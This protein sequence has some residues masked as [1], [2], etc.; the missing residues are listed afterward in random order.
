MI[1]VL[2]K[3]VSD[4]VFRQFLEY[5]PVA[6]LR[7]SKDGLLSD[8]GGELSVFGLEQ[9]VLGRAAEDQVLFLENML[10]L[11]EEVLLLPAVELGPDRY[12][13]VHLLSSDSGD[14]AILQDR[15]Q[16]IHWRGEAQ[17]KANE[18]NLLRRKLAKIE[19][20]VTRANVRS[21]PQGL[22]Y[23]NA[24][25]MLPME[26]LENGS[27]RLLGPSPLS[28]QSIYPEAF[29]AEKALWPDVKFP[30]IENFLIE[31]REVWASD[32]ERRKSGPWVETDAQGKE[33]ALEAIAASWNEKKILIIEL[34]GDAYEEQRSF[35]QMGRENVLVRKYLEEEVRR[36][37]SDIH[38]RE[39]EI[40]LRLVW[41]SESRDGGETG[42]HIRRIGLYCEV[43]AEAVGWER[44]RVDEIRIASTMHD[45][46]KIG[47]PD[48]VLRKPGPLTTE[49]YE[50]MK[51]HPVIG[52]RILAGSETT[53]LQMAKDI[54]LGHHEK[55]DGSGYPSGLA[56]EEIPLSARMV[57]IADVFD[58]LVHDR[59]YKCALSVEKAVEI[60]RKD[61]GIHFDPDLFDIFL[62][63]LER[64][65]E[66]AAEHSAPLF[67]GFRGN[68]TVKRSR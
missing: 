33:Y 64:F 66:I 50:V 16:A 44:S 51:T 54:A 47:I 19:T 17:Q 27:F 48:S 37:T 24:L 65:E 62:H 9:L 12:A 68:P 25:N 40:A 35:L 3:F 10:P 49:E 57:A 20:Q 11:T 5:T 58:A 7:I 36:R 8:M 22:D 56:R 18:L 46:G 38:A 28:F 32:N 34:L 43:L 53:L 23:C 41:V 63:L 55:W 26:P 59:V 15:S 31:A 39:E 6:Y 21:Y 2:P 60:M 42:S 29:D 14:W 61:R 67:E 52:G 13:D 30:F 1:N 45:I 4:T